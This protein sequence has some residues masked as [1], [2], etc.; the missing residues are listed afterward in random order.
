MGRR[1]IDYPNQII[2][3]L[4]SLVGIFIAL[5]LANWQEEKQEDN[6]LQQALEAIRSE[7]KTNL[8]IYRF[9]VDSLGHWLEYHDF[10]MTEENQKMHGI[11]STPAALETMK[12]RHPG[13]LDKVSL[14][15]KLND[16]TN[17]Y[18]LNYFIVSVTPRIGI[19]TNQ[20]EASKVSGVI[21]KLDQKT[22]ARLTEIYTLI[23]TDFGENELGLTIAVVN[24]KMEGMDKVGERYRRI[25][26]AS[27]WKSER[28][29]YLLKE[30][31]WQ[32]N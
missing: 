26:N 21:Q 3:F 8:D 25:A 28:I 30:I 15:R 7:I 14:I 13:M 19:S 1:K 23:T 6:R 31:G 16:S 10:M 17:L 12:A 22:M 18:T 9:N 24:G 29:T 27:K 32:S 11:I 4:G 5:Q 20:W 2:S